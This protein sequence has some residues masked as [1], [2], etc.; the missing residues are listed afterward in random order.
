MVSIGQFILAVVVAIRR[1]LPATLPRGRVAAWSL[2]D[3]FPPECTHSTVRIFPNNVLPCLV[4]HQQNSRTTHGMSQPP[5]PTTHF[6]FDTNENPLNHLTPSKQRLVAISVR[7][8]FRHFAR[9]P[10]RTSFARRTAWGQSSLQAISRPAA[11]RAAS[12]HS[13][14][15]THHCASHRISNRET[16]ELEPNVT[17]RKQTLAPRSNR[18]KMHSWKNPFS[19][20]DSPTQST[21]HKSQATTH[22]PRP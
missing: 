22:T 6:L 18:Q 20:S 16:P 4:V 19:A 5:L 17:R 2:P 10:F 12:R 9:S 13:S 14:L 21:S 8:K 3:G 11:H 1:I 15:V 7:Y